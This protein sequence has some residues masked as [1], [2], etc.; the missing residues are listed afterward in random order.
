M[1]RFLLLALTA[2]L[3]SPIAV[4]AEVD[5]KVHKMCL[6]AVDYKG[7]VSENS[8]KTS[9]SNRV[10]TQQGSS[11][12]EGN[13][14]PAGFAYSG[15]G[16]CTQVICSDKHLTHNGLLLDAGWQKCPKA[17]GYVSFPVNFGDNT[18]RAFNNNKCPK[19][20]PSI[21]YNSTCHEEEGLKFNVDGKPY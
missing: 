9:N 16:Y 10:I 3:L 5:P 1:K 18:V 19:G 20:R 11:V 4:K 13:A 12:N 8:N 17:L 2:G 14:C 15:G 6:K 7:C 21:G